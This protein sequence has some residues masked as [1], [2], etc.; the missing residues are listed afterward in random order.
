M[1]LHID[2]LAERIATLAPEQQA[3]LFEKVAELTFQRGLESL[4]QQYRER[5]AREG[6]LDQDAEQVMTA[7]ERIREEVAAR[8]YD[9]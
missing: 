7:L 8:D 5:L 6:Q 9:V 4:A 2:Q 3:A 1:S